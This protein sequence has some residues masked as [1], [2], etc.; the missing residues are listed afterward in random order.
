MKKVI[1]SV[2]VAAIV[3]AAGFYGYTKHQAA[4]VVETTTPFVKETS[5]RT[6][7]LTD[8]ITGET[9]ATFREIF[10]KADETIKKIDESLILLESSNSTKNPEAAAKGA[11]Y[12]RASQTLVRT[13]NS[14]I[15]ARFELRNATDEFTEA[16]NELKASDG[17][18]YKYAKVRT[19]K[20]QERA[21]KAIQGS[22]DAFK[23]ARV[24]IDTFK[25]ARTA[26]ALHYPADS[27]IP[28]AVVQAIDKYF[29]PAEAEKKS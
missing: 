24:A 27:L 9:N 15:R 26:A 20:A 6:R 7:S 23:D 3:G 21:N 29:E 12:L 16:V 2:L 22:K 17:Y 18:S 11:D 19:D 13:L 25:D 5:V 8:L 4:Q 28:E 14:N 1:A 10:D